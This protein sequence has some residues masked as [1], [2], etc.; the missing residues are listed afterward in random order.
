MATTATAAAAIRPATPDDL[1]RIES[2]LVASALPTAGVADA[3][4]GF[5]VAERGDTIVGVVAVE[6]CG[7]YGLLRSAAVDE[8]WRGR[9][10]GR[11]L[12]T[13][14]IAAA[15]ATGLRSLYLL[16]TTAEHYFLSFGFAVTTRDH[17]PDVVK[18]NVEFRGACPASAVVMV[19]PIDTSATATR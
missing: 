5:L 16:T 8:Q 6:R 15:E 14:A 4:G 2:L 17:V 19:R 11:Q 18:E 12:V 1:A 13:R 9:G 10:L 3:L 7:E